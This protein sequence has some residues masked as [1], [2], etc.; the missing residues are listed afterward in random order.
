[1]R[2]RLL[3]ASNSCFLLSVKETRTLLFHHLGCN[4]AIRVSVCR[5][6]DEGDIRHQVLVDIILKP[7]QN[8]VRDKFHILG[9]GAFHGLEG[10]TRGCNLNPIMN[11]SRETGSHS[12]P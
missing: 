8:S 7:V 10:S 3:I 9:S 11:D 2:R 5:F 12:A 4:Q 1:M 6:E